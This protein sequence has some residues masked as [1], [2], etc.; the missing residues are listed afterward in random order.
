MGTAKMATVTASVGTVFGRGQALLS[1][2]ASM[3][4]SV[5]LTILS[6]V[7]LGL[8]A[9]TNGLGVYGL[10]VVSKA[11]TNSYEE[12]TVPM[13]AMGKAID[14]LNKAKSSMY[15]AME[16]Q[17][18][19]T[20]DEYLA[21]M[22]KAE[23]VAL[24]NMELQLE[25]LQ[26]PE[27]KKHEEVYKARLA[28]YLAAKQTVIKTFV[29]DADRPGA[30]VIFRNDYSNSF[31][32]LI[33]SINALFKYQ[34][35]KA[36]ADF[37]EASGKS[38]TI[39]GL[40]LMFTGI[41]FVVA[42]LLSFLI[43]TSIVSP[44][45]K[46]IEI[47][48]KISVGNLT[49]EIRVGESGK[50]ETARLMRSLADMQSS[51]QQVIRGIRDS[52]TVLSASTSTLSDSFSVV[53]DGSEQQS[54]AAQAI[55]SAV[56]QM[57]V[58]FDQVN[59]NTQSALEKAENAVAVSAVGQA[60]V[61]RAEHDINK[62]VDAVQDAGKSIESLGRYS[63]EINGIA[64]VIKEIADQTN[65]LA[66]NAAIEAARAGEHGRGFA[67][68]ADEVRKLAEKTTQATGSIQ[69]VLKTVQTETGR[70]ANAMVVSSQQV[71]I[72]AEA[73]GEL[74]PTFNELI[75][76]SETSR[77]DL[78]DLANSTKEQALTSSSIAQSVERIADMVER[79]NQG[80]A[81][82]NKTVHELE[83]LAAELQEAVGHFVL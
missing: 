65:L 7:L 27:E 83:R 1:R 2:F 14:E 22:K 43:I 66:L 44:L 4:V 23:R 42:A 50:D 12:R 45:K 39:R 76:G 79:N 17:Y 73:V 69:T 63:Q 11:L 80:I 56:E 41:G 59:H 36:A 10:S 37:K 25:K 15:L 19:N 21:K 70:A 9:V 51:L 82:T 58:S 77:N 61:S 78:N 54:D 52:A 49:S 74:I 53:A 31:D 32:G 33:D 47:A 26:T 18:Q 48:E 24:Q 34:D 8:L 38:A 72:G 3:R 64:A 35:E 40:N 30:M 46:A 57:T 5:R 62:I 28:A 67:V 29:D 68:V 60:K 13:V 81:S 6:C 16:A 55:A 71:T 20:T 75:E